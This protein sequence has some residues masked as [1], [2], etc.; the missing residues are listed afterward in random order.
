VRKGRA[1]PLRG[2]SYPEWRLAKSQNNLEEGLLRLL[3][4]KLT[5]HVRVMLLADRGFGR[6]EWLVSAGKSAYIM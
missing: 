1:I 4:D 6:A 5:P 3:N 2:A